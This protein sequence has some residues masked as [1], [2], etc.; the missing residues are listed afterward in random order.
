[1]ICTHLGT[2]LSCLLHPITFYFNSDALKWHGKPYYEGTTIQA[3]HTM[4]SYL[5]V[6]ICNNK[7]ESHVINFFLYQSHV[8]EFYLF[9]V[10]YYTV[11]AFFN[12]LG[13]VLQCFF[14]SSLF[15][16][17]SYC[18]TPIGPLRGVVFFVSLG[19]SCTNTF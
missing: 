18:P 4:F 8:V 12:K 9:N 14:L 15:T 1:M 17:C 7:K 11:V 13:Q 6:Q 10:M 16:L 19:G 5:S 3:H 2:K